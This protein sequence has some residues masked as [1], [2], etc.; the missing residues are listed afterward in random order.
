[1]VLLQLV[2]ALAVALLLLLVCSTDPEYKTFQVCRES[3]KTHLSVCA[4]FGQ[5]DCDVRVAL[6]AGQEEGSAAFL[7]A[8]LD[9]GIPGHQQLSQ[10]KESL[11]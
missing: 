6:A 10:L 2:L 8:A 1:M 4:V 9:V 5:H 7:G 11:L 3:R